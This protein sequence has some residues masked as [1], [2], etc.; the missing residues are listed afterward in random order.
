MRSGWIGKTTERRF[1]APFFVVGVKLSRKLYC[2]GAVALHQ[3]SSAA[4]S[5]VI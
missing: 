2:A 5:R 3:L 1:G 4:R